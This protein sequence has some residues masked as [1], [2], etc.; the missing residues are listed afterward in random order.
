[1]KALVGAEK[2]FYADQQ[3]AQEGYLSKEVDDE[4]VAEQRIVYERVTEWDA[5]QQEEEA[6]IMAD[7]DTIRVDSDDDEYNSSMNISCS[8]QTF[9]P[10]PPDSKTLHPP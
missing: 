4:Y 7:D 9:T 10:P 8:S 2:V 3:T 1:M 5:R 6:Y